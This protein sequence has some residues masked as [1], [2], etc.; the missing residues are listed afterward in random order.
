MLKFARSSIHGWGL[1]TLEDIQPNEMI[2]EYVGEVIRSTIAD[3]RELAYTRRGIGSSYLFRMDE[4]SVST[5]LSHCYH[6]LYLQVVDATGKGNVARFINHSCNPNSYARVIGKMDQ[7]V[8]CIYAKS[9]ITKGSEI[10]YDYKA[11]SVLNDLTKLFPVPDRRRQD[12]VSLWCREL[13][14]IPQLAYQM[15]YLYKTSV[16]LR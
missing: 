16:H 11:S 8:I 3:T 4:D 7:R 9:L 14:T 2:I 10:V 12:T 5:S 13:S 15:E 6:Y 1:F